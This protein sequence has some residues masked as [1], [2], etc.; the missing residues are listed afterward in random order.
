MCTLQLKKKFTLFISKNKKSF[1]L[2]Y[3]YFCRLCYEV[4][5][6][7]MY[8]SLEPL[9][10]NR[11]I[12][13]TSIF[14]TCLLLCSDCDGD[15]ISFSSDDE[16]VEILTQ[17]TAS[18][19]DP[20]QVSSCSFVMSRW[21]EWYYEYCYKAFFTGASRLSILASRLVSDTILVSDI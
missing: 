11:P 13:N 19:T 5:T 18:R 17:M 7:N 21:W 20:M 9:M 3:S 2:L 14:P 12:D 4:I 8:Q 15:F 10:I 1:F 16:L 6:R